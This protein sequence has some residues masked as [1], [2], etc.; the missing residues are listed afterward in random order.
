M[1]FEIS[2]HNQ[3]QRMECS[4]KQLHIT[5]AGQRESLFRKGGGRKLNRKKKKK[6]K[7]VLGKDVGRTKGKNI[8]P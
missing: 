2:W 4:R 6:K 7:K 5:R 8:F 3:Q 1:L